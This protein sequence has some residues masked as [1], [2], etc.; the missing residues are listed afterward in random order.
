MGFLPWR[1]WRSGQSISYLRISAARNV[2]VQSIAFI[3]CCCV[4]GGKDQVERDGH[5]CSVFV[6]VPLNETNTAYTWYQLRWDNKLKRETKWFNGRNQRRQRTAIGI[7][8]H[9][10]N[11]C[12]SG[13][14]V[15][16]RAYS[17]ESGSTG[18][19]WPHPCTLPAC[20]DCC[21]PLTSWTDR[22][23]RNDRQPADRLKENLH[24]PVIDEMMRRRL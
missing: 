18:P 9:F 17:S 20:G 1:P 5:N 8:E 23:E 3:F 6:L 2:N 7:V 16:F 19:Y 22:P 12:W 11:R 15:G 24:P 4:H 13:W 10:G 14:S 21:I